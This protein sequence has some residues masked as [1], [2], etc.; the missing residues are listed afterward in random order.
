MVVYLL[1]CANFNSKLRTLLHGAACKWHL[2]HYP[3]IFQMLL[4]TPR[5]MFE[6]FPCARTSSSFFLDSTPQ[7]ALARE[8]PKFRQVQQRQVVCRWYL[9]VSKQNCF[10]WLWCPIRNLYPTFSTLSVGAWLDKSVAAQAELSFFSPRQDLKRHFKQ[11]TIVQ[12]SA[13]W[14][15][16][17]HCGEKRRW[18]HTGPGAERILGSIPQPFQQRVKIWSLFQDLD[19]NTL[20]LKRFEQSKFIRSLDVGSSKIDST[21]FSEPHHTLAL[22]DSASG[23]RHG[24]EPGRART[25][26]P[27]G[28]WRIN[29]NDISVCCP[30]PSKS[31]GSR[32]PLRNACRC[33]MRCVVIKLANRAVSNLRVTESKQYSFWWCQTCSCSSS[34]FIANRG[35]LFEQQDLP[36]QDSG[37]LFEI[38]VRS[39]EAV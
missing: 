29:L 8:R 25:S 35:R 39:C 22:I 28:S 19:S 13:K 16:F 24:K 23:F 36:Q 7:A 9:S 20:T 33:K 1:H 11:T 38:F 12:F 14:H 2:W 26:G 37:E 4:W 18:K 34:P 32:W 17:N 15:A 6:I 31:P 10:L 3:S 30:L 27:C 21:V 5:K